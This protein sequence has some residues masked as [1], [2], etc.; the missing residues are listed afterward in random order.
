MIGAAA[1]VALSNLS[2]GD[3]LLNNIHDNVLALTVGCTV[4]DNVI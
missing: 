3:D 4:K 2:T 1:T